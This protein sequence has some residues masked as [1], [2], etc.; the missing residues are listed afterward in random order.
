MAAHYLSPG[1]PGRCPALPAS[2]APDADL[3]E[4][5]EGR[6]WAQSGLVFEELLTHQLSLQRLRETLRTST[7]R[8][9]AVRP[10]L[11]HLYLDNLGFTPTR[12]PAA[13]RARDRP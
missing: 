3:E 13:R 10:P 7:L 8:S 4:L 11:P 9:P 5:A 1:S 12:R 2:T 6:H